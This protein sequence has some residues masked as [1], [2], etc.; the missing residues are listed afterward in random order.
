MTE[1]EQ[2]LLKDIKHNVSQLLSLVDH[3]KREKKQLETEKHTLGEEIERLKGVRDDFRKKY[4][5]LKLARS[6]S[7]DEGNIDAR[8]KINKIVRE[9]DKCIA[10]LNR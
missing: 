4:D 7:G 8:L 1:S 10:L 3:L 2:I 6:M 5:N 9:I